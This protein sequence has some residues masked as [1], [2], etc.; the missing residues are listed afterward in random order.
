MLLANIFENHHVDKPR[1]SEASKR[2]VFQG[3]GRSDYRVR[4]LASGRKNKVQNHIPDQKRGSGRRLR[5]LSG[6]HL[7]HHGNSKKRM[8]N[9]AASKFTCYRCHVAYDLVRI[10]FSARGVIVK[11]VQGYRCPICKEELFTS[12]QA[13]EIEKRI[14][15]LA[16][17]APIKRKVSSA[18]G[19]KPAIYLPK[20]LMDAVHLKRLATPLR[21]TVEG[22]AEF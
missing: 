22:H 12:E 14:Y 11:D 20:D 16:P 1:F 8:K 5:R 9:M 10:D 17:R 13:G 19:H 6:T 18:S 4:S 7:H 21:L 15:A 2:G 3:A